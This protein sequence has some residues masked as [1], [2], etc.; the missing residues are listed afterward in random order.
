MAKNDAKGVTGVKKGF[1]AI[2]EHIYSMNKT[3]ALKKEPCA[4]NP[5]KQ[6]NLRKRIK[7]VCWKLPL[8]T[9]SG[10]SDRSFVSM[11]YPKGILKTSSP[12]GKLRRIELSI[13]Q[14]LRRLFLCNNDWMKQLGYDYGLV[15]E[16]NQI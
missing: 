11:T 8:A 10:D 1:K 6:Q 13:K 16:G 15:M 5:A 9:Y 3:M 2:N 7:T 14:T 4:R 12:E